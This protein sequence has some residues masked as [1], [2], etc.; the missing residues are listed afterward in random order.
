MTVSLLWAW[1]R[2]VLAFVTEVKQFFFEMPL[3]SHIKPLSLEWFAH[4]TCSASNIGAILG[5]NAHANARKVWVGLV[6]THQGLLK[7]A[8]CMEEIG[9]SPELLQQ[10]LV[11]N[12]YVEDNYPMQRGRRL[13]PIVKQSFIHDIEDPFWEWQDGRFWSSEDDCSF[14]TATPDLE[15]SGWVAELKAPMSAPSAVHPHYW[16]QMQF[17]MFCTGTKMAKFYSLYTGDSRN[18]YCWKALYAHVQ[19]APEAILWALPILK[20]WNRRWLSRDEKDVLGEDFSQKEWAAFLH[21]QP[22]FDIVKAM[23]E[24]IT[25]Q[26]QF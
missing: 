22:T 11:H 3:L 8:E 9:D 17:Q 24:S 23:K 15:G 13:E 18:D 10:F 4:R 21:T 12:G 20:E 2:C 14:I 26:R 16:W 5:H 1:D 6:K 7:A 25:Q 19:R